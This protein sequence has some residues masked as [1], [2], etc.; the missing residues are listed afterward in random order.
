[1]FNHR[2]KPKRLFGKVKFY[3]KTEDKRY[4]LII[5]CSENA[6]KLLDDFHK[7]HPTATINQTIDIIQ[8]EANPE[9]YP[10]VMDVLIAHS[11]I[12]L[13][14][15]ILAPTDVLSSNVIKKRIWPDCLG[16]KCIFWLGHKRKCEYYRECM[17]NVD[18]STGDLFGTPSCFIR[19]E[20]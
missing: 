7:S 16:Y 2:P 5:S 18:E 1:M 8:Q 19:K 13:G 20:K 15:E 14:D 17:V 11:E 10:E 12:G 6:K 3:V 9:F 4:R